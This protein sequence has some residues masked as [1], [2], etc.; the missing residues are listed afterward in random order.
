M[1]E[2]AITALGEG[3]RHI[4]DFIH[5]GVAAACDVTSLVVGEELRVGQQVRIIGEWVA[6]APPR[7]EAYSI[8]ILRQR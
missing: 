3:T 5:D 7:L 6:K 2:T 8:V 4:F 1:V